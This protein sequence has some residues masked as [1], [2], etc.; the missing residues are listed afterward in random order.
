MVTISPGL[1][2]VLSQDLPMRF[3]GS[4]LVEIAPPK[5]LFNLFQ[6]EAELPVKQD[7]LMPGAAGTVR[8]NAT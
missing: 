3:Q 1:C 2:Q 5:N 8:D 7:L 4:D 6:L